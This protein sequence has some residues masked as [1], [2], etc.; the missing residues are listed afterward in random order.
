MNRIILKNPGVI[1]SN[2]EV[3]KVRSIIIENGRI[4]EID[5]DT[6]PAGEE[7]DCTD[8]YI[9]PSL[10]NLH[11]HSPMNIFKG[12]AEDVTI[13]QW[14]NERIWPYEKMLEPLDAYH[15]TRAAVAEMQNNGVT[16]FADHYM[17]AGEIVQASV[18]MDM[19]VDIAPTL[20]SL[21]G[22]FMRALGETIELYNK[23]KENKRVTVSLGPHSPYT[24]T[25]EDLMEMAKVQVEYGFKVHIHAAETKDQVLRSKEVHGST[26]FQFLSKAGVLLGRTIIAHG[27]YVEEGD[28]LFLN[29]N[30]IFALSPK[31]YFKLNM[32]F[33][34]VLFHKDKLRIGIGTDG[35][36]SS[37]T[38]DPLEQARLLA[39]MGKYL[40]KDSK[41]FSVKE[42]WGYL[43]DGHKALEFESGEIKAG[44]SADLII[45]D[46]DKPSTAVCN[47][48][49]ASILFSAGSENIEAV[50]SKGIFV[51]KDGKVLHEASD[52]IRYLKNRVK[53]LEGTKGSKTSLRY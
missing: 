33:G 12:F 31:T 43:M 6:W 3:D 9:S 34:N 42:V 2:G 32:G 1:Y 23:F 39:L 25:M 51:K 50:I 45:W 44:Y 18:E 11:T 13:D 10:V 24:C 8:K 53:E 21:D 27:L 48:P 28:L 36:A 38:L 47:N 14:F 46:L 26:P 35:S 40:H 5:S 4:S 37:N 49:L 22:S 20:F 52:S 30:T 16:A 29:E 41:E 17:F 15:G 19:N 7:I